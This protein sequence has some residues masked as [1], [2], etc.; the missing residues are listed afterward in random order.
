VENIKDADD[1]VV[2]EEMVESEM[3]GASSEE[4]ALGGA[5]IK[6]VFVMLKGYPS[7]SKGS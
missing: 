5:T 4:G 3:I 2:V 1:P 7:L 6:K